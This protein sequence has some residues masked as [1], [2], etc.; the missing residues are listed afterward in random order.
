MHLL[1]CQLDLDAI[2]SCTSLED[3]VDFAALALGESG[4]PH[5]E[6]WVSVAARKLTMNSVD[7]ISRAF[8]VG[9]KQ[10]VHCSR[11]GGLANGSML[12]GNLLAYA[13]GH[14]RFSIFDCNE[15]EYVSDVAIGDHSTSATL[16]YY[17]LRDL[18]QAHLGRRLSECIS[19]L[20]GTAK[21][22]EMYDSDIG[23]GVQRIVRPLRR[24]LVT[25][26]GLLLHL[27]RTSR[28]GR[29]SRGL[30]ALANIDLR[31]HV[32]RLRGISTEVDDEL[33][34]VD[35][36]RN[37]LAFFSHGN[38]CFQ[39]LRSRDRHPTRDAVHK[40]LVWFSAYLLAAS[41]EE[42]NSDRGNTALLLAFRAL[43]VFLLAY[44]WDTRVVTVGSFGGFVVNG[45]ENPG[46]RTL[47]KAYLDLAPEW[48][49]GPLRHSVDA[50]RRERNG[51][52]LTH[53]FGRSDSESIA[54]ARS[55]V[56][57]VMRHWENT[58]V[59]GAGFEHGPVSS[60]LKGERWSG[61]LGQSIS[62][63]LIRQF[64][65]VGNRSESLPAVGRTAHC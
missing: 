20:D 9:K 33:L 49:S 38:R 51:N 58:Y 47:W 25:Y 4:I 19:L 36:L 46:L 34:R 21:T 10:F 3:C 42:A 6:L 39:A 5:D 53:G 12:L 29:T 31:R 56:K 37:S 63:V 16:L 59:R 52:I 35:F 26:V 40:V 24:Y 43:E 8:R 30:R 22:A 7:A 48:F 23:R 64:S 55:N 28:M 61:N 1:I 54:E 14:E 27:G 44:L 57:R 32:E 13:R 2:G 50:L 41:K 11:S 60:F 45:E 62:N 15:A 18:D 65:F 17:G